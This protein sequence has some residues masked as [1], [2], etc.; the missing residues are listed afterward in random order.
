[1]F[2]DWYD[3]CERNAEFT[4]LQKDWDVQKKFINWNCEAVF[5]EVALNIAI[6]S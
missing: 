4:E 3:F 2:G 5:G 1:M 6:L